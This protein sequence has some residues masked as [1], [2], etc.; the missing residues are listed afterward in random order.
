[1]GREASVKVGRR[2][3][4][5]A[6]GKEAEF[7]ALQCYGVLFVRGFFGRLKWLFLGK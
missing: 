2:E 1:M 7:W 5:Q 6:V 4:R 3:L